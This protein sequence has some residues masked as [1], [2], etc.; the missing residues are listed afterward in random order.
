MADAI[1]QLL[2]VLP[3]HLRPRKEYTDTA[4]TSVISDPDILM[5]SRRG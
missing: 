3:Q 4:G 5:L 1:G 2:S